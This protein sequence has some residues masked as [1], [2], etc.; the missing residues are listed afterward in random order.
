M[1]WSDKPIISNGWLIAG[2]IVFFPIGL[3][4]LLIRII[5]HYNLKVQKSGDMK[6]GGAILL[7][8]FVIYV[9][10]LPLVTSTDP[11]ITWQ[12]TVSIIVVMIIFFLVPAIILL[13]QS[14]RRLKR[15]DDLYSLYYNL[16]V[17]R[18]VTKIEEI[19]KLSRQRRKMVV[20]DLKRMIWLGYFDGRVSEYQVD[21]Y[22]R[23]EHRSD[24]RSEVYSGSFEPK[25][26]AVTPP[27]KPAGLQPKDVECPGCGS[28]SVVQPGATVVC[29]YCGTSLVYPT[30]A[31]K[32]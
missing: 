30:K 10:I 24:Y 26:A 25:A 13:W 18:N 4:L 11:E 32:T 19:A 15:L 7:V 12:G 16:I 22:H 27:P 1:E 2:L 20:N 23:K 3:L 31:A 6:A 8:F 5:L 28:R 14:N 29:D 21:L 9:I 17:D